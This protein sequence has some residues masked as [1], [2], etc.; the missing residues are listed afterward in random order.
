MQCPGQKVLLLIGKDGGR[1][2]EAAELMVLLTG[3]KYGHCR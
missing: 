1:A 3:G 2:M